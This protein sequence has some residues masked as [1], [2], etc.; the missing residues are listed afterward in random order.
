MS[1]VHEINRAVGDKPRLEWVAIERIRVDRNYQ[2]DLKPGRVK[3]ILREFEWSKFGALQLAE[4]ADGSFHVF[5]GQHR[6]EAARLHPDVTEVPA[7]I[8]AVDGGREEADAFLG[9]NTN[10]SA[11]TPIERYWAGLEAGYPAMMAVCSV[12]DEAG[13]E[14]VQG[15]G[16]VAPNKTAAVQAISRAI[17]RYG[18][19][20]VTEAIRLLRAAWPTAKDALKG[21]LISAL[22]RIVKNNPDMNNK[23]MTDVLAGTDLQAL[24]AD[25]EAMRKISGGDATTSIT[26]TLVELYNRGI[27]VNQI[28]IGVKS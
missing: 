7:V 12:L 14:V 15:L 4:Q 9:V 13:C 26:K 28:S 11:V 16:L 10:R 18:E 19:E 20:A 6:H 21:T 2:S 8:I 25:A 5:D 23:R 22:S 27:R 1:A 24:S 17:Q 3:Q